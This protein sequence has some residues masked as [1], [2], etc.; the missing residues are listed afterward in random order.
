MLQLLIVKLFDE[1]DRFTCENSPT[2]STYLVGGAAELRSPFP[3][4][5]QRVLA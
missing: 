1:S 3:Y 4:T 5:A 2:P